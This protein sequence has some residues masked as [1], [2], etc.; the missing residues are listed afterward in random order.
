MNSD[1]IHSYELSLEEYEQD[2]EEVSDILTRE[3]NERAL[4]KSQFLQSHLTRIS[5]HISLHSTKERSQA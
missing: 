1:F 4:L 3:P 5:H 2:R